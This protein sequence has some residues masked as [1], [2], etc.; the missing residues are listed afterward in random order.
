MEVAVREIISYKGTRQG[1]LM[2]FIEDEPFGKV[3]DELKAVIAKD[4][5]TFTCSPI[6]LDLGWREMDEYDLDELLGYFESENLKLL[7]I[8]STSLNTRMVAEGRG[9]KVIIGRLGLADHMGRKKQSPKQWKQE[10][11]HPTTEMENVA[12]ETILMK[13]TIRA[14]QTIEHSGNLVIVGDVNQGAEVK[15]GGDIIIVGALH[16]TAHAGRYV[17]DES[18]SITA[19][20]F[21]PS[22]IRISDKTVNSFDKKYTGNGH[23]V[24]VTC[25]KGRMEYTIHE[26]LAVAGRK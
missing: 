18:A 8:I 11:S 26:S 21:S 1:I 23:A 7:G 16:G 14:G 6:S 2:S 24:T 22:S 19:L 10:N 20:H 5:K 4:L 9:L 25:T 15:A 12:Q 17:K 3:M 13:K